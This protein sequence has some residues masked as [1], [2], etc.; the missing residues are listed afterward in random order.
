MP[1][2][3]AIT[4]MKGMDSAVSPG[5]IPRGCGTIYLYFLSL[6]P[7]YRQVGC[8][9]PDPGHCVHTADVTTHGQTLLP[10]L[11]AAV[12]RC[13][14]K[15]MLTSSLA[16]ATSCGSTDSPSSPSASASAGSSS[17]SDV[18]SLCACWWVF[19]RS[20]LQPQQRGQGSGCKPRQGWS[21]HR[22]GHDNFHLMACKNWAQTKIGRK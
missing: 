1:P 11:R 20:Q 12:F 6:A 13:S 17:L 15:S 3:A 10:T 21:T 5:H 7:I 9:R 22:P 14:A 4:S 19:S 2:P 18:L 8:G 16:R